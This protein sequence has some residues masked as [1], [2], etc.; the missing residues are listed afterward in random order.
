MPEECLPWEVNDIVTIWGGDIPVRDASGEIIAVHHSRAR[1][2]AVKGYIPEKDSY[3]VKI[4][5]RGGWNITVESR[6]IQEGPCRDPTVERW[7]PQ[8]SAL[9]I[10]YRMAEQASAAQTDPEFERFKDITNMLL[11]DLPEEP[12]KEFVKTPDYALF[13]KVL[14]E[15]ESPEEKARFVAIV[16]K[17]LINLP[18]E[19]VSKFVKTPDYQVYFSTVKKYV[20]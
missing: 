9:G 13:R 7:D 2:A 10:A 1:K 16:D 8:M 3:T 6:D 19:S 12:I 20:R 15:G 5:E 18:E 11:G 4:I 17:L 14:E